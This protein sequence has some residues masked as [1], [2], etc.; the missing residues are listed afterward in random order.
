MKATRK[1]LFGRTDAVQNWYRTSTSCTK[2][3]RAVVLLRH[4]EAKDFTQRARGRNAEDAVETE[5]KG[6]RLKSRRPLQ[7]QGQNQIRIQRRSRRAVI[8]TFRV[9]GNAGCAAPSPHR[10]DR[11][12]HEGRTR[13]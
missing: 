2:L 5:V 10:R 8:C 1:Q 4:A 11:L 3:I 6:A 13:G 7:R 9:D 12:C